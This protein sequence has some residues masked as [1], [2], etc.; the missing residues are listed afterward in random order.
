[1]ANPYLRPQK[2]IGGAG[3][4]KF[5]YPQK[6]QKPMNNQLDLSH[7]FDIADGD[8]MVVQK[9]LGILQ[10]NLREYPL[11]MRNELEKGDWLAL[12]ETAHKF[13]SSTAYAG[14]PTFNQT[15]KEIEIQADAQAP[16]SLLHQMLS[17]IE[18]YAQDIEQE[19]A[20]V[21]QQKT[22]MD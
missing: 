2:T 7:L 17:Q 5:S 9:L 11:K 4:T 8:E 10:K 19:V 21:I 6:Q 3:L 16:E 14:V 20:N 15:L 1:V 12:R 22:Q 18:Q 13:K